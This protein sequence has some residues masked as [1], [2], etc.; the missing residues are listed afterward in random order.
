MEFQNQ[1]LSQRILKQFNS[2]FDFKRM[3]GNMLSHW[4]W[5]VIA[6]TITITAGYLYLRY[7]TSQYSVKS[8][9]LIDEQQDDV[10]KNVLSKLDPENDQSQVNLFNEIYILRSQD[11]IAKVIDS[12]N[13]NIRYRV[14]GRIKETEIYQE[15]PIAIVFDS[16]GYIGETTEFAV[17]QKVNGQFELRQGKLVKRLLTDTWIRMPY[18][19]FKVVYREG[20]SINRGYLANT[21]FIIHVENLKIAN[22]RVLSNFSVSASDGRT[23]LLDLDYVDNIPA[24]GVAFMNVLIHFYQ[25][26][27]LENINHSAQRTREFINQK[28]NLMMDDLRSMDS[29]TEDIQISNDI[30][31]PTTQ[32]STFQSEKNMSENTINRLLVQKQAVGNLRQSMQSGRSQVVAGIMVEDAFLAQLVTQ[33]NQSVQQ[34]EEMERNLPATNPYVI[35]QE[36]EL[37]AQRRRIVDAIDNV[38]RSLN[39]SLQNASRNAEEYTS[40]I[41]SVPGVERSIKNVQRDYGVLQSIY[42]YLYQKGVENEIS[43]YAANNKSKI[44]VVPYALGAPISPVSKNVYLMMVMLGLMIP[45]SYLLVRE[46]LNNKVINENDIEGLTDIPVVGAISRVESTQGRDGNIVVGPHIRTGVAEQFRLIR[47]NLEFMTANKNNRVYM[48]TSSTSGEG[49]SFISI[50]LGITMTLAKKRVIIMEFDLRKPK[51]SQY[52]GLSNEGGISGYLA[53]ISGIET[54]IKASGVHEN[55]YVANCGPIPPNPGE[56]LV[57]PKTKELIE[58][59]QDMFDVVIIDTAPIG[60]VSDALLLSQHSGVNLFVVR[61]S[62]TIKDQIRVF[63]MLHKDKKIGNP[64]ILFNG[65]EFLKKY[66]YGYG[67]VGYGYGYGYGNY[68][69]PY[70]NTGKKKNK[71][72]KF[73][74]K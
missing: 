10:A 9:I 56:L 72:V 19:R 71:L 3:L 24:R 74:T 61:Q 59:L 20:P 63:D 13:L 49:K 67:G 55:L 21:E 15:N 65:V 6:I 23:S 29:I 4:Y 42:L 44:V 8:S 53:G 58:S 54:V 27:E 7:T 22:A 51:I 33:Y 52:L 64:A 35:Q 43:V 32:S 25:K 16:L 68:E 45:G 40:R 18:G 37:T 73:F 28:K 60:L 31:D 1:Q 26:R 17:Q 70:A 34:K 41:R 69:D 5:F 30:I 39:I 50:N 66:G 48:I 12:L 47:A 62:Y 11:L 14:I 36:N 57:L 38:E 46:L 2:S